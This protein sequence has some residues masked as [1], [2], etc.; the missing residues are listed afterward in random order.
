MLNHPLS[1]MW[2]VW[3]WHP[4]FGACTMVYQPIDEPR[5]VSTPELM[6][7][8]HNTSYTIPGRIW[9]CPSFHP[10]THGTPFG[11]CVTSIDMIPLLWSL[12]Q[13]WTNLIHEYIDGLR[14]VSTLVWVVGA[15]GTSHTAIQR[16][17]WKCPSFI[18]PPMVHHSDIV[19]PVWIWSSCS[20]CLYNGETNSQMHPLMDWEGCQHLYGWLEL[21]VH[22]TP[23]TAIT[24]SVPVFIHPPM[25]HP[26][27]NVSSAWMWSHCLVACAKVYQPHLWT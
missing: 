2:S 14:G 22:H 17:R 7:G 24:V 1:I 18:H 21:M 12:V 13:W 16:R 3:V 27:S 9:K 20:G 25:V 15:H 6:F 26:L 19:W 4:C 8:S 11:Y 5:V 23:S 10:S